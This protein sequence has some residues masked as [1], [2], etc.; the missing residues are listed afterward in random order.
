MHCTRETF[1][2]PLNEVI[3]PAASPGGWRVHRW[4]FP[5]LSTLNHREHTHRMIHRGRLSLAFKS[6]YVSISWLMTCLREHR[7]E[8]KGHSVLSCCKVLIHKVPARYRYL[9][10]SCSGLGSQTLPKLG[11]NVQK[12]VR[13]EFILLAIYRQPYSFSILTLWSTSAPVFMFQH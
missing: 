9:N 5:S 7:K 2:S 3:T 6:S 10:D 1:C 8:N 11:S 4:V 13:F 12:Q